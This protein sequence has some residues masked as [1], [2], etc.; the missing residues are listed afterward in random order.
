MRLSLFVSTYVKPWVILPPKHIMQGVFLMKN[1]LSLEDFMTHVIALSFNDGSIS[2]EDLTDEGVIA[3]EKGLADINEFKISNSNYAEL[4]IDDSGRQQTQGQYIMN[5]EEFY[6]EATNEVDESNQNPAIWAKAL[7]LTEGD[8][9]KAKYEYIKLRVERL[10]ADDSETATPI[11]NK[12]DTLPLEDVLPPTLED[13][14]KE[15][16]KAIEFLRPDN[17][18]S[19]DELMMKYAITYIDEKYVY[20]EYKYDAL[21]DA[22]Y[23]AKLD[24]KHEKV[25]AKNNTQNIT[26]STIFR[27]VITPIKVILGLVFLL[28]FF[29]GPVSNLVSGFT[30]PR[31]FVAAFVQ[32]GIAFLLLKSALKSN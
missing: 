16:K 26:G 31:Y 23:Y 20:K 30:E 22:I 11:Q 18:L 15:T 3:L 19:N 8:K 32:G 2:V 28:S 1:K 21:D 5:D 29:T 7:A 4:L 14:Q 6:L 24:T 12:V 13:T 10:V 9:E 27:S 17:E 25:T